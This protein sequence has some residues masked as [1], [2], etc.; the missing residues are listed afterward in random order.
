MSAGTSE[1][2][3][4]GAERRLT[5]VFQI[6]IYSLICLASGILAMAEG[7]AFPQILTF[8]VALAAFYF[9][10]RRR[11]VRLTTTW[12][13][14][15]GLLAFLLAA[16][17][18]FGGN[19][20]GKLLAGAHL[21]VYLCWIVLFREKRATHYWSVCA[22]ATLQVAVASVLTTAG[23]F[24]LMLV[25][26]LFAAIWTLAVFSLYEAE[27][28][29][30]RDQPH[31]PPRTAAEHT[32]ARAGA[33]I[34]TA[35][36]E[37][38][39]GIRPLRPS[40]SRSAVLPE[41]GPHSIS[42]RFVSGV[43]GLACLSLLVGAVFFALVPRVWIGRSLAFGSSVDKPI[44]TLTGFT[45]RVSL[46]DMGPILESTD[47]VLEVRLFNQRT[48][49][50]LG[51]EEY[52][53]RLGYAEP[54]FRG[55][56]LS[57]YANGEWESD[58]VRSHV[59]HLPPRDRAADVRQEIHLQP[60]GTDILFSLGVPLAGSLENSRQPL[61][62]HWATGV[63]LRPA[64]VSSREEIAYTLSS[65]LPQKLDEYAPSI[66]VLAAHDYG[67]RHSR[68]FEQYLQLPKRRLERLTELARTVVVQHAAREEAEPTPLQAARALERH[69]R[70]SGEYK[71]S[72]DLSIRDPS[73]D[74]VEDF[75]FNRQA[76][77]CE[78]FASALTL[79]L[80][81][82][83]IPARMISGFK[84][85]DYNALRS[86]WEVQQRHAHTWVE[87]Y[88]FEGQGDR[89]QEWDP[90]RQ[91]FYTVRD[92]LRPRQGNAPNPQERP[93]QGH[94]LILDATPA[95][96]R[97]QSVA[98]VV[99]NQSWLRRQKLNFNAL[100][101]QY[102][103]NVTPGQQQRELYRPLAEAVQSA[104]RQLQEANRSES[105]LLGLLR[106][107]ATNP[108]AWFSWQGGLIAFFGLCLLS[109]IVWM[110]KRLGK[111]LTRWSAR[112]QRRAR[113][114][115]LVEF[116]ERF[117]RLLAERGLRR[118]SSQTQQ[119][120]AH[121]VAATLTA[122]AVPPSLRQL[123]ERVTALFYR[124]RF[125]DTELTAD[126]TRQIEQQLAEFEGHLKGSP[127]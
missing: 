111:M 9:T 11:I 70:D 99:E 55:T 120:F 24:G 53:E 76:G 19:E 104:W 63:L 75:L 88:V 17:E 102:V 68:Y 82:V 41:H 37:S 105:G 121:S 127:V 23:W 58:D 86:R 83:G 91:Q 125:G 87:A 45:E 44:R 27:Q 113:A 3:R 100:W 97:D 71:Y 77:H 50:P 1:L 49:A 35:A 114:R 33:Q 46:G 116:Y 54:I 22:M 107:F 38:P 106:R 57:T 31:A 60:I 43:L 117:Q 25:V 115:R 103:V 92:E 81:A 51:V 39:P 78:Y 40:I 119:E 34:V 5:A 89:R 18:F 48:D 72:L 109:G 6:S 95:A 118:A 122:G 2:V 29:V 42:G 21:I 56:V 96:E 112:R 93:G 73:I 20:E 13:N 32:P 59:N 66:A 67:Y 36:G 61:D 30:E 10:E 12:A 80:R 123:P 98:A 4:P 85:G 52:T 64:A 110:V 47:P 7:A 94:W 69:L 62:Q 108:R 26:F 74:P 79:M 90:R 84:G 14:A 101:T 65:R 16:L 28:Q 8:P 126:E 15:F 124:V